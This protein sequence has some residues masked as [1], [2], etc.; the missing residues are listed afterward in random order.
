MNFLPILI[1]G[2]MI[3]VALLIKLGLFVRDGIR[4]FKDLELYD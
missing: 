2:V 3:A 1:V 4:T